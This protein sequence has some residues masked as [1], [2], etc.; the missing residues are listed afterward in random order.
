MPASRLRIAHEFGAFRDEGCSYG[1][2]HYNID[3]HRSSL[4]PLCAACP[5]G[6]LRLCI[7]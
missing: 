1:S 6:M 7:E 4:F 3:L 5:L 2:F